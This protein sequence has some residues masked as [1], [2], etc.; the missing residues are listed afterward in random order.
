MQADPPP[1]PELARSPFEWP[2]RVYYE[3]TDAGGVVYYANYFRFCE[4]ARTEYLRT[5]GFEQQRLR[6]TTGL[7]FVVRS[8]HGDYRAPAKLDDALV[9]VT[10]IDR[11]GRASIRFGQ[12]ILRDGALLFEASVEVACIDESR[13]RAT[14]I[15]ADV[16]QHFQPPTSS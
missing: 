12:K 7:A 11:L 3:D 1:V 6:E 16:R 14:A 9:V 4:R 13:G 2:V 10:S 15:P 5:A 8:V